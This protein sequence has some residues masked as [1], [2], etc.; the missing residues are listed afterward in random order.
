MGHFQMRGMNF[1]FDCLRKTFE[2]EKPLAKLLRTD[3][4]YFLY[5]TGTNK[6]LGCRKEVYQLLYELFTNDFNKAIQDHIAQ[7]GETEFLS[8]AKDISE[9]IEIEK[10]LQVKKATKFGL[11]YHFKD[12]KEI[13]NTSVQGINLEVTCECPLRCGYCIYQD[14]YQDKRN[15]SKEEMSLGIA[16]KSIEFLKAHSTQLDPVML[17]FYGGEPLLRFPFIKECVEFARQILVGKELIFNIT[18]NAVLITPEIAEYLLKEG[19]SILVSLDGPKEIHDRYRLDKNGKGS[20]D[21]TLKGL[22]ILAEKHRDIKKGM[23]SI[24]VVYAPPYSEEKINKIDRFLKELNWLPK[25]SVFINYPSNNSIPVIM[26]SE[27]KFKENKEI[28]RWSFEKYKQD[29]EQSGPMVK[30]QIEK[31]FATFIQRPVLAEPLDSYSLNGCCLPGQ[32]K[33]YITTDGSIHICEKISSQCPPIGTI[34][35]GF[36]FET[37]RK[38]YI[39]DYV[40][41]SIGICSGCWGIRLCDVCY[42]HAFN[43]RG[44]LDLNRKSRHCHSILNALEKSLGDFIAILEK[45][46][47]KLD[48]LYHYDIK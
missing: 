45:S 11:S 37:I 10:I 17:G 13:L 31:R 19:F 23:I 4:G 6:I 46:P 42:I 5:D 8:S 48:Y 43:E 44:E 3:S 24:N 36:D 26:A 25:A 34:D 2:S 39:A 14:H 38:V 40:E 15:F 33:S 22:R 32:R 1:Y 28:G 41:K 7:F 9:S 30:G 12:F 18:T 27:K 16:K 35:K 47:E 21:H 20:F 29:F